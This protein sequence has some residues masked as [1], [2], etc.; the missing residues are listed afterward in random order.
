MAKQPF[1]QEIKDLILPQLS[2]ASFVQSLCDDLY[3]LFKVRPSVCVCVCI[4]V[5]YSYQ[6]FFVCEF[7]FYFSDNNEPF[8]G[9][10]SIMT[11]CAS[12]GIKFIHSHPACL[13]SYYTYYTT[14][15]TWFILP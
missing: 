1:S 3:E 14:S 12:A 9:P 7:I 4:S 15:L 5:C 8:D 13:C 2:D 11:E 6:L 10:L